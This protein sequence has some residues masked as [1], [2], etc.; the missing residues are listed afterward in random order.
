MG[1]ARGGGG[2]VREG[3]IALWQTLDVNRFAVNDIVSFLTSPSHHSRCV[4]GERGWGVGVD[5]VTC[6]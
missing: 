3:G 4:R 1:W 5:H 6:N 2:M